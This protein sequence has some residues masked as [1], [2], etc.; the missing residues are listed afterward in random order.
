MNSSLLGKKQALKCDLQWKSHITVL[1]NNARLN[2]SSTNPLASAELFSHRQQ[3]PSR[4]TLVTYA[5]PGS[6]QH[7]TLLLN[8]KE[9]ELLNALSH[10]EWVPTKILKSTKTDTRKPIATLRQFGIIIA[11][12]H[13]DDLGHCWRLLG[14]IN[15]LPH[16]DQIQA[17]AH[18]SLLLPGRNI[19]VRIEKERAKKSFSKRLAR[20]DQRA[21]FLKQNHSQENQ[22]PSSAN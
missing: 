2:I 11:T 18:P 12:Y 21:L 14:N 15:L 3:K 19:A 1:P 6:T 16:S 5:P 20:I 8:N 17:S 9:S 13:N 7:V 10:N 4:F 22:L